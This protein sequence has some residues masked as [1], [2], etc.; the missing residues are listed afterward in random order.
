MNTKKILLI[1]YFL[2]CASRSPF[3]SQTLVSTLLF[4]LKR[5]LTYHCDLKKKSGSTKLAILPENLRHCH[6][7]L[8]ETIKN[9]AGAYICHRTLKTTFQ[10]LY[11]S[12]VIL[13]TGMLN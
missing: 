10:W 2:L 4:M 3:K 8:P 12:K 13:K 7:D 9:I 6:Q 11:K 1:L 5:L